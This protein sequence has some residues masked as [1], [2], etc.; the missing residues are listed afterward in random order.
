MMDWNPD[1]P[2]DLGVWGK[3]GCSS[4]PRSVVGDVSPLKLPIPSDPPPAKKK[5]LSLQLKK[6]CPSAKASPAPTSS[7]FVSPKKDLESYQKEIYS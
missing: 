6:A 1:N 7:R 3:L 2:F 4:P 5:K